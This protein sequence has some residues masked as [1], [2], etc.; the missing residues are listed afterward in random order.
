MRI[1]KI[2]A[3][4]A[5]GIGPEVIAAGL[6]VL[7]A[8]AQQDGGFRIEVEKFPWSSAYYLEHGDYI[9]EGGLERL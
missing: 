5:D 1:H 2:A 3:I 4:G 6:T 8:L 9:P 7:D